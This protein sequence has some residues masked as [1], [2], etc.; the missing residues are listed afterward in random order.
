MTRKVTGYSLAY[1]VNRLDSFDEL[2]DAMVID[3]WEPFGSPVITCGPLVDND[4]DMYFA[5]A[6][7]YYSE[8]EG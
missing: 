8:D 6:M 7:V 5:Q 2:V 1:V 4:Y 3:G